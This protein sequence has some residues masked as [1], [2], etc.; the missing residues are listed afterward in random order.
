MQSDSFVTG[1]PPGAVKI[2]LAGIGYECGEHLPEVLQPWFDLRT[3]GPCEVSI[4]LAY[5]IF[6]EV[7]ALSQNN[8]EAR[9]DSLESLQDY[10]AQKKIDALFV[11]PQP[12]Y[13]WDLRTSTL[14]F[15]VERQIDLLWLLDLQDEIYSVGEI[16]RILEFI[17]GQRDMMWFRI[18]FKNYVFTFDSYVEDFVVPRIWRARI[19]A[20]L[21]C[22]H[23]D[24]S[25]T[26]ED[27][28]K[29]ESLPHCTIPRSVAFPKHLSWVGSPDYLKRKI[30]YQK[31]HF[32]I[33]S[34]EWNQGTDSL[35]FNHDYYR[36]FG[37]QIPT[38]Y[39]EFRGS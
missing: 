6:P 2:G 29:Q 26:Y 31:L 27:G 13:E 10:L 22:F 35:Q 23:Y 7:Y 1:H 36:R 15:L 9:D 39:K 33:C 17:E 30:E 20:R 5:G 14:P 18:N 24:N 21:R 38:V 32:G 28:Q 11:S 12:R 8:W 16:C 4:S 34:Y 19:P 37:K 3:Y 25:V